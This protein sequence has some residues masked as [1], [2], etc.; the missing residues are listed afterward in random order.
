MRESSPPPTRQKAASRWQSVHLLLAA[1]ALWAAILAAYAIARHELL[2]STTFDLGIKAQVI[3]NTFQGRW[4]ASSIEVEHYLGDHVQFIFLLLAPLFALWADVKILLIVQS[5]LLALGAIPVFRLARRRL[6]HDWP[7]LAFAV[8][9]LLYPTIGF[10]NRFDFHPLVF[11]ALFL[12]L[13][14][15]FLETERVG[16]ASGFVVLSLLCREEVGF[17]VFALGLYVALARKQRRLG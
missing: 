5:V 2:N 1:V 4:F 3:W 11:T 7:A 12:L 17:T 13:A 6:G 16:W 15:D 9:Y 8:A 14:L 10:V